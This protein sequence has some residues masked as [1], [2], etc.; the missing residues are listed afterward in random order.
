M[1]LAVD[2]GGTFT[3]LVLVD[4]AS[5]QVW[6]DKVPSTPA[7]GDAVTHG[8]GRVSASASVERAAIAL[9][10]HGFT[11]ATNA[12]LTRSGAR[13][14]LLVSAGFG[15]IL[16][17]GSQRR[18]H[19]YDLAADK[20]QPLVPRSHVL[21]VLEAHERIDA[22]G[23]V[24]L[25]LNDLEIAR[26]VKQVAALEPEAIAVSLLFSWSNAEHEERLL[27][28]LEH[29]CAGVPIY[30]FCIVNPQ[31]E[32]YPRANTTAA[33]AYVGP[34]MRSYTEALEAALGAAGVAAPLRYM[35]SDGGAATA[36]AARD[37]PATMLLSGPAGGVVAA[38]AVGEQIGVR[39]LITFD[40]GGMSADFSVIRGGE[41]TLVR[42]RMLDG[43]PLRVP[44]L[45]IKAISAG[46][47][48]IA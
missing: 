5:A 24:V 34:P 44:M 13:V 28:A 21:E 23:T 42:D 20:P 30:L 43:L 36:L 39:E 22:F 46:G 2:V 9:L 4:D 47:G 32:E 11:I 27:T 15:D 35:R 14:A 16:A 33:A 18:P 10:F 26:V 38:L 41:A 6:V 37:N 1:R 48:S 25:P 40:M 45:D 19:T 7:S 29:R 3:D 12:W 17:L 8:I 31:I